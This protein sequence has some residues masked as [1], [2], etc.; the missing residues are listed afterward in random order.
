MM[1]N[2]QKKTS[3]EGWSAGDFL[4]I[5]GNCRLSPSTYGWW[6]DNRVTAEKFAH[7]TLQKD[8]NLGLT[9]F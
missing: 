3:S 6:P 7:V 8:I 1:G 9:T 2:L 4:S 5:Q